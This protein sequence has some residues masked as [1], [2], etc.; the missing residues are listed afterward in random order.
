MAELRRVLT[1]GCANV[2]GGPANHGQEHI[3]DKRRNGDIIE[4]CG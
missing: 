3:Q 1:L 4:Y 2:T